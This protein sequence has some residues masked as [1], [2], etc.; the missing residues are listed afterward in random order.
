MCD[1]FPYSA[2][3][4]CWHVWLIGQIG[5]VFSYQS[6]ISSGNRHDEGTIDINCDFLIKLQTTAEAWKMSKSVASQG[7]MILNQDFL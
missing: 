7:I 4:D 1:F 5:D 3:P 6:D 2:V